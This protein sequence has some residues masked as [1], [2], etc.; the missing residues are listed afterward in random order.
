[1][2]HY[3]LDSMNLKRRNRERALSF[4]ATLLAMVFVST[5]LQAADP[6]FRTTVPR[7]GQRGTEV[8]VEFTGA[9]LDGALEVM[10]HQKGMSF[11][12]LTVVSVTNKVKAQAAFELA[13]KTA[14]TSAVTAKAE[15]TKKMAAA[16]TAFDTANKNATTES[17]NAT[18]SQGSSS[19]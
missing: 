16:K 10:F 19:L 13:N 14:A 11:K 8:K 18:A 2:K 17:T 7:G 15:L 12:D 9:R 4:F 5:A 3:L 1:M 6:D